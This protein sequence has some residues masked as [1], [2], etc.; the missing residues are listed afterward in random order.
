MKILSNH[1]ITIAI[2]GP[3]SSGKSTV[4]KQ[5]ARDFNL[6]YID[7]GAMYRSITLKALSENIDVKDEIKLFNL[8]K[9]TE[10]QFSK[11]KN[12]QLVYLDGKDVTVSIRDNE[13]TNAV[14]AVS[15]HE[16]VR[17]EMVF[18][19]REMAKE[20]SVIMDGRDIGTVVL[21]DAT[22]KIFL[23]ASVEER[24]KR[25]HKENLEKGF[26]S[27][28]DSLVKEIEQRDYLDSNRETSPLKKAKD[29]ILIDSTQLTIKEVI[30][31]I[32]EIIINKGIIQ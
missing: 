27:D 11:E 32:G 15:A 28:Y 21:P 16:K 26:E 3:A 20:K 6:I 31:K 7:T 23:N 2:D 25:R 22:V 10:I 8:L 14:S 12:E 13:V 24:A 17:S 9:D 19:Q 18:R 30:V 1:P 5:I 4:A 29:A